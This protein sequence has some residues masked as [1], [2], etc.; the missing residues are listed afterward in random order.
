MTHLRLS[1]TRY[2]FLA[3]RRGLPNFVRAGLVRVFVFALLRPEFSAGRSILFIFEGVDDRSR[4]CASWSCLLVVDMESSD[5]KKAGTRLVGTKEFMFFLYGMF[6]FIDKGELALFLVQFHLQLWHSL[7]R[8]PLRF[9]RKLVNLDRYTRSNLTA[10]CCYEVENS[11]LYLSTRFVISAY[12][13]S[14][15]CSVFKKSSPNSKVQL[16]FLALA[17]KEI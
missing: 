10:L 5:A 2:N 8:F 4:T 11:A 16:I 3:E 13:S 9:A 7:F 14:S 12:K 6:V 17:F 1:F 15:F